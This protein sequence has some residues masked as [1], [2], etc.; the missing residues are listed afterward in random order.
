MFEGLKAL[1]GPHEDTVYIRRKVD[2]DQHERMKVPQAYFYTT[3]RVR[4]KNC[5]S[6]GVLWE[7][8][9]V[10]FNNAWAICTAHLGFLKEGKGIKAELTGNLQ[11]GFTCQ[12]DFRCPTRCPKSPGFKR[13]EE[14]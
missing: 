7:V 12:N 9:S 2:P 6:R 14:D 11:E 3:R 10:N 8:H 5:P 13:E 1:F 4:P